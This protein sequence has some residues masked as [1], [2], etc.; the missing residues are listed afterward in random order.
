M[1]GKDLPST[2]GMPHTILFLFFIYILYIIEPTE[3][4]SL[5]NNY[6]DKFL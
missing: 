1:S 5:M 3:V 4:N 6:E 2:E